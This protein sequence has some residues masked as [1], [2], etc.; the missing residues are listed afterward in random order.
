MGIGL[1]SA[2]AAPKHYAR[3]L[4]VS[5]LA[6]MVYQGGK[7]MM[8]CCFSRVQPPF[9]LPWV[10]GLL[11]RHERVDGRWII[12]PVLRIC[13]LVTMDQRGSK[14]APLYWGRSLAACRT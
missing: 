11:L 5:T 1:G 2:W 14:F 10:I 12:S 8:A 9:A 7:E 4:E 3:G 13:G 6:A